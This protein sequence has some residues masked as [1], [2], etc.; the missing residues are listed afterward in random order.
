MNDLVLRSF[1]QTP[2]PLHRAKEFF[3]ARQP[4]LDRNQDLVAYELLFRTGA[5]GPADVT[6]DVYATASVI[7]HASELGLE[8][9]VGTLP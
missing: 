1:S 8:N 7:A 9:V 2:L 4:I 6:D 3:L 5:D